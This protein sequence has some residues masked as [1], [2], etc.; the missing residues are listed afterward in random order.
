MVKREKIRGDKMAELKLYVWK[1]VL[2][3]WTP[4]LV[5]VLANSEEKAWELLKQTNH[6]VWW[7]LLGKPPRVVEEPEAFVIWGGG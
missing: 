4:G 5:C 7:L 3:D 1:D 2:N 6:T